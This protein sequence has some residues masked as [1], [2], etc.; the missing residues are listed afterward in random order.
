[1][2]QT[3]KQENGG[4]EAGGWGGG[5]G[6]GE[7]AGGGGVGWETHGSPLPGDGLKVKG[8]IPGHAVVKGEG[9]YKK[10]GERWEGAE[11]RY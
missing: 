10:S 2:K 5:G 11:N 6:G 3:T 4:R 1:L 9:F 8:G 7:G